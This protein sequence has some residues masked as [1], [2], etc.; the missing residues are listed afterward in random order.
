[1]KEICFNLWYYLDSKQNIEAVAAKAYLLEGDDERK[2]QSLRESSAKDYR[3]IIPHKITPIHYSLLQEL[4]VE[5]VFAPEFRR[6]ARNLPKGVALPEDKLYW[7]TPLFDFGA[8]YVPAEI[9]NGFIKDR[10]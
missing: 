10:D 1:M 5:E 9:G 4:G 3:S 6:I 2:G 8:G 7:A